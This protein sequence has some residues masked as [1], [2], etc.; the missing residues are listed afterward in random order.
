MKYYL[1]MITMALSASAHAE[2]L[3]EYVQFFRTFRA[4]Q[5]CEYSYIDYDSAISSK[6]RKAL[7]IVK[8]MGGDSSCYEFSSGPMILDPKQPM[9]KYW[10]CGQL[11]LSAKC[12]ISR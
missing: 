10:S 3:S 5:I 9:P 1:V 8:A 2:Y 11:S 6:N 12:T 7:E 4:V